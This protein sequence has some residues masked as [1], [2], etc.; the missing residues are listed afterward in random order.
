M[1]TDF[2]MEYDPKQVLV[3]LIDP[4]TQKLKS[5]YVCIPYM[6]T[7]P[8]SVPVNVPPLNQPDP[9]YITTILQSTLTNNGFLQYNIIENSQ[10]NIIT[11]NNET[12]IANK[13]SYYYDITAQINKAGND[14]VDLRFM[15][16]NP[17]SLLASNMN[18]IYGNETQFSNIKDGQEIKATVTGEYQL[19]FIYYPTS[20]FDITITINKSNNPV[21][22]MVCNKTC[23]LKSPEDKIVPKSSCRC[24]ELNGTGY[25]KVLNANYNSRN[26]KYIDVPV[27]ITRYTNDYK[28]RYLYPEFNYLRDLFYNI[29]LAN[30]LPPPFIT[31]PSL[32]S[33]ISTTA[34]NNDP[35]SLNCGIIPDSYWVHYDNIPANNIVT[36]VASITGNFYDYIKQLLSPGTASYL[37]SWNDSIAILSSTGVA[38]TFS[39]YDFRDGSFSLRETF[40]MSEISHGK[41]GLIHGNVVHNDPFPNVKF[42]FTNT[43]NVT[44]ISD[45]RFTITVEKI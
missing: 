33:A 3:D 34:N 20:N 44:I 4:I 30:S 17:F 43:E 6:I 15:A 27:Y 16:I 12:L 18:D 13:Y 23:C 26:H 40:K 38:P 45:P 7:F 42:R 31:S 32:S 41:Y 24:F 9:Q 14:N 28:N 22:V 11:I 19:F 8:L 39:F 37:Y 21:P 2:I 1:Q 25:I 36:V 10:P 29:T 5:E 35:I